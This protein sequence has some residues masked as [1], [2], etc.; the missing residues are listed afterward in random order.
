ML[1]VEL[2]PQP[3]GLRWDAV[4][5]KDANVRVCCAGYGRSA[6][7]KILVTCRPSD[8]FRLEGM[9]TRR[10]AVA[11]LN[12]HLWLAMM[13]SGGLQGLVRCMREE[14]GRKRTSGVELVDKFKIKSPEI[15]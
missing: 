11:E 13:D 1:W 8:A 3:P 7:T 14:K 9:K 4:S 2:L 6:G 15:F 5:Q 12:A 10:R